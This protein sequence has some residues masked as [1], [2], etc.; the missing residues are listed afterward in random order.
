MFLGH[1]KAKAFITHGGLQGLLEAVYHAVPLL[2]LPLGADQIYNCAKA[3]KEGYAELLDWNNINDNNLE[4][5]FEQL[6]K[7][8]AYFTGIQL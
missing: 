8:P 7:N 2:C 1:P 6:I 4:G 5:A 3:R